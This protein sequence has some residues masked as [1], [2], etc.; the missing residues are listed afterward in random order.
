MAAPLEIRVLG[1]L[2][3]LVEGERRELEKGNVRALVVLLALDAGK[4][5]ASERIVDLLWPERPPPTA[6][7]MVRIYVA[8]AR[9]RL[10][11]EAIST[12][13]GSYVLEADPD[14]VDG[15]RFERLLKEGSRKLEAQDAAG[16]AAA[17]E[18]ALA[19][20]RGPPLAELESLQFVRHEKARLEELHLEAV[21]GRL[22]AEL[23]LGRA[24]ELVPELE[25]LVRTHPYRERL[26]GQL[27]LALYRSGRQTDAL[28]RYRE[29]RHVLADEI[30]IEPGPDLKTLEMAILKQDPGLQRRAP[31][32]S[33]RAVNRAPRA[34]RRRLRVAVLVV[35]I[36]VAGAIAVPLALLGGGL[37]SS[38]AIARDSL[39]S[40]D[41][42]S[43]TVAG[44]LRLGGLPG[45]V[46]VDSDHIWVGDG[47]PSSV[48][49]VDAR[50]LTVIRRLRLANFPYRLAA[51]S[52]TVWVATGYDGSITRIE[53]DGTSSRPFRAE[54]KAS[55]RVQLAVGY[56]AL[57]SAS[58][59]GVLARVDPSSL[60]LIARIPKVGYPEALAVGL[61]AVWL[62]DATR[63]VLV[64]F[65][66][67]RNRVV[68][69]IPIGGVAEDI[70][71]GD[72]SVWA[73]T[74]VQNRLWRIDPRTNAVTAAI[75][76]E[77][78]PTSVAVTPGAVWV[79]SKNGT[80]NHVDPSVNRVVST[81][82]VGGP[83]ADLAAVPDRL[84]VTTR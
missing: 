79:G 4:P 5:V 46:A 24:G 61:G 35:L 48:L 23:E 8:R 12:R 45:P 78:G 82:R 52:G 16:A 32:P 39:G 76:V 1:P 74:P 69:E 11:E 20:W 38:R 13:P 84:W 41:P 25:G 37:R 18:Q 73:V 58:Q 72:G 77:G 31:P 17:L 29:G 67:A 75:A 65:D 36:V 60:R 21:E 63:F 83:V 34:P 80:I 64:R 57:W 10:G 33:P 55:G 81:I 40:I 9:K 27:M 56:S 42:R 62:A 43:G 49:E 22:D 51:G 44:S 66:P 14:S 2:E 6:R 59:D 54:P 30:G 7:E 70:A 26:R 71:V 47:K 68:L 53:A 50:K 19:L 15:L 28:A 3:V